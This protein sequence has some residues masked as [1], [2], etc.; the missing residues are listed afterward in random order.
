MSNGLKPKD[1]SDSFRRLI[2]SRCEEVDKPQWRFGYQHSK[3]CML[4]AEK[5]AIYYSEGECDLKFESPKYE[6]AY[7]N[8]IRAWLETPGDT[9]FLLDEDVIKEYMDVD[10][11]IVAQLFYNHSDIL[12]IKTYLLLKWGF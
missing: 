1:L 6:Y 2:M 11:K 3:N 12:E 5:Q 4:F 10:S 9:V 8:T 7:M